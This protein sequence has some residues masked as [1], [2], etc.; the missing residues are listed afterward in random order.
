MQFVQQICFL[1]QNS[2]VMLH[3]LN[4]YD[5]CGK[6]GLCRRAIEKKKEAS[7]LYIKKFPLVILNTHNFPNAN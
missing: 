1:I 6:L 5:L 7:W 2:E 4:K 3:L